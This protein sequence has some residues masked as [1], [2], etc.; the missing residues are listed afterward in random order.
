MFENATDIELGLVIGLFEGEG[1]IS[2]GKA[3]KSFA[4]VI[5]I[6]STDLDVLENIQRIVGAGY[7]YAKPRRKEGWKI[8]YVWSLT[9][10]EDVW[11]FVTSVQDHLCLRRHRQIRTVFE[12]W[13]IAHVVKCVVCGVEFKT[14]HNNTKTCSDSCRDELKLFRKREYY[15]RMNPEV[16]R[17]VSPRRG[18]VTKLSALEIERPPYC[19]SCAQ[20][21]EL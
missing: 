15:R 8:P 10:A 9:K 13:D 11:E 2:G 20:E 1:C 14:R 7:I 19:P 6:S 18:T 17:L 21:L 5:Q 4:P 3:K 16:K 12:K